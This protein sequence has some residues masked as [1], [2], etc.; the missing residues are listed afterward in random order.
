MLSAFTKK[1]KKCIKNKQTK[2][3]RGQEENLEAG[4]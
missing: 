2:K 4:E 1:E 3:I